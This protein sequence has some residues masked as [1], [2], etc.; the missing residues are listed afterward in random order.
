[1]KTLR[2]IMTIVAMLAYISSI[3]FQVLD[4]FFDKK[5]LKDMAFKLFVIA[6]LLSIQSNQLS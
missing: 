2:A 6:S 5:D 3:V 1:M 4:W